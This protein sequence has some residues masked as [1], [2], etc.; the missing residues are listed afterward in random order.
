MA[1]VVIQRSAAAV[2]ALDDM[3]QQCRIDDDDVASAQQLVVIERAAVAS[4]EAKIGGPILMA[5]C[6]DTLDA[7]PS[8]PW[9][10]LGIA[11]GRE[12]AAIVV[13][14]DGVA[15]PLSLADFYI[16]PDGRLL[17]IKPL[18]GWPL[19][20]CRP[21]A[22]RIDYKA[23]FGETAAAVPEDIRQWLRFRVATLFAFREELTESDMVALPGGVVDSLITHYKPDGVY[24]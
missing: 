1:A 12:V 10:H 11:G 15:V 22:I 16:E 5:D 6:R 20:D 17:C 9:F 2:L 24:L 3:R 19:A 7:W 23:G 4:A 8:L 13:M 18:R 21:G 14:R